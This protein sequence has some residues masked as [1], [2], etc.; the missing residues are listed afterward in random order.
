MPKSC[1]PKESG[2]NEQLT[3][4]RT[5]TEFEEIKILGFSGVDIGEETSDQ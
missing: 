5:T 4:E 2:D 3:E 1:R